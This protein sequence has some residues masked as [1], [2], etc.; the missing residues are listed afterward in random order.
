[1]KR[2]MPPKWVSRGGVLKSSVKRTMS[3]LLIHR[4]LP[5]KAKLFFKVVFLIIYIAYPFSNSVSVH[6]K[7]LLALFSTSIREYNPEIS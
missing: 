1:M 2:T 3:K 5:C 6:F 7:P 4:G